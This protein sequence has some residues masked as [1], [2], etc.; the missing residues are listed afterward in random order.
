[1]ADRPEFSRV[2]NVHYVEGENADAVVYGPGGPA[3]IHLAEVFKTHGLEGNGYDW[4]SAV[5]AALIER[6][7]LLE[8]FAFASESGMFCAYGTDRQA[9]GEVAATLERLLAQPAS[10][11]DALHSAAEHHLLN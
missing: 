6:E 3:D 8:R 1:M 2:P 7:S 10:L 4:E 9:L 5:H 11:V